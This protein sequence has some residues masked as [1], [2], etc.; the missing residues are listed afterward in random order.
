MKSDHNM[1]PFRPFIAARSP[2]LRLITLTSIVVV[3]LAAMSAFAAG[4]ARASSVS[5]PGAAASPAEDVT[6]GC[7]DGT[8]SSGALYRICLPT[9]MTWNGK[10]VVYAHG[11][12]SPDDPLAV[13]DPVVIP[14]STTLS[15]IFLGQGYA[16]AASS[17]SKNGLA[18]LE[19]VNDLADLVNIFKA[20]YPTTTRVFIVGFSEGGLITALSVERLPDL[21]SGGIAGCGEVGSY[22]DLL[23]YYGDTRVVFDYFFKNLLPGNAYTIPAALTNKWDSKY[24]PEIKQALLD[25]PDKMT[26]IQNVVGIPV[27][28]SGDQAANADVIVSLLKGSAGID[29]TIQELGGKPYD[30]RD[31]VYTGSNDDADLNHKVKRYSADASA[32]VEMQKYETSGVLARP[33]VTMHTTRDWQVP[34]SQE[35]TYLAKTGSNPLHVNLPVNR[36]GHCTFDATDLGTALF[37]LT[38]LA[39]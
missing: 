12:V 13:S 34:Y 2:R 1:F 8:Q 18:V 27:Q 36:D 28:T 21:Y 23:D 26:Q 24:A 5:V 4:T 25:N 38:L 32:L 14:P 30:N 16:F 20:N 7:T 19:G 6:P 22:R 33:L 17:Y 10:V 39:P 9:T 31:R 29:E 3:A 35:L 11:T 15:Q 37:Y